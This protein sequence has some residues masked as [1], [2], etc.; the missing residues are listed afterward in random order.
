M[1]GFGFVPFLT[2]PHFDTRGRLG[3]LVSSLVQTKLNVGV[4][5]DESTALYYDNGEAKVFGQN[6]VF[7]IDISQAL[8]E[9]KTYFAMTNI[10]LTYLTSGDKFNFR[11]GRAIASENKNLIEKPRI[12]GYVDSSNI[13]Y[14]Y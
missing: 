3:R 1:S 7:I 6:G 12:K 10:Q 2:D 8:Y 11:N 14:A 9:P 4:G 13:F 5:I